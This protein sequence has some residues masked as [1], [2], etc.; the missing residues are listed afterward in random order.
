MLQRKSSRRPL[1]ESITSIVTEKVT[2]LRFVGTGARFTGRQTLVNS[3][4]LGGVKPM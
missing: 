4:G 2:T 1:L 3:V